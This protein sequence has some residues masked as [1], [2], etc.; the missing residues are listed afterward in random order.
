[1]YLIKRDEV[2]VSFI[3]GL[4]EKLP[5]QKDPKQFAQLREMILNVLESDPDFRHKHALFKDFI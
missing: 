1:M 5:Q 4:I 3:L 2:N